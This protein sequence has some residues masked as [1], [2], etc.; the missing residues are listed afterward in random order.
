MYFYNIFFIIVANF[1]LQQ[2]DFLDNFHIA[3]R[4]TSMGPV[5]IYGKTFYRNISQVSKP[6]DLYLKL[7]DRS[8]IW[9]TPGNSA[10]DVPV[11]F[12]S[13]TII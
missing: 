5:S 9:Q 10:A 1:F 11:K 6:R 3:H 12:H 8:E 13:D 7:Y 2:S 4:G